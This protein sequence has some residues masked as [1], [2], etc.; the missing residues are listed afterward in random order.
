MKWVFRLSLIVLIGSWTFWPYLW[1]HAFYHGLAVSLLGFAWC[2][3]RQVKV[4][5][6]D[7]LIFLLLC[8]SNLADELF[9]DPTAI[10]M[11]EY[12]MAGLM[13]ISVITIQFKSNARQRRK[14]D[15]H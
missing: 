5:K 4:S 13:V 7:G 6:C 1:D 14:Q 8:L 9:F 2:F 10:E 12:L 11:N 3:Y 15:N